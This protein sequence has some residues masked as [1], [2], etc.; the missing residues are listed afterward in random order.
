MRDLLSPLI[1]QAG[2]QGRSSD[3]EQARAGFDAYVI[4]CRL[5]KAAELDPQ[6]AGTVIRDI[7]TVVKLLGINDCAPARDPETGL[8]FSDADLIDAWQSSRKNKTAAARKLG[9]NRK[10]FTRRLKKIYAT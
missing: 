3:P 1:S 10:T 2:N 4:A 7:L 8:K 9:C 5:Q 6:I